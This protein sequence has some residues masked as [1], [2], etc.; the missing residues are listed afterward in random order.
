MNFKE[1]LQS[2]NTIQIKRTRDFKYIPINLGYNDL[3]TESIDGKRHYHTPDGLKYPS[4]TTVLGSLSKDFIS[5][6]KERVGEEKANQVSAI[7]SSR[8]LQVH[9]IIE[10]YLKCE[11]DYLQSASII[12]QN[13][14]KSLK[15][16]IDKNIGTIFGLE[17]ALYSDYLQLAGRC[18]CIAEWN[19][20]LSIIDWKTS[21]RIKEKDDIHSYF[22]QKTAYAIMFE[23]RTKKPITNLITV[24]AVD[25]EKPLVFKEHRDNWT[26][27]LLTAIADYRAQSKN[28]S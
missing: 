19:G 11:D 1:K 24:I 5:K 3:L 8:G 23:E 17:Y 28:L 27:R 25:N 9:N 2:K 14:F 7:A 21:N 13:N 20:I 12:A 10:K 22:I 26:D 16:L 4:I 18:D 6:W 15:P